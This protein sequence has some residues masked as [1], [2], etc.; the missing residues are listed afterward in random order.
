MIGATAQGFFIGLGLVSPV[1]MQNTWVLNQG[2]R[3]NHHL[4]VACLCGVCDVFLISVGVNAHAVFQSVGGEFA[5]IMTNA[6][7]IF[8]AAY[9]AMLVYGVIC[10]T[11]SQTSSSKSEPEKRTGQGVWIV[12][13]GTLLVTLLNPHVLAERIVILG[14][15]SSEV[16]VDARLSFTLGAIAASF[17]WFFCLSSAAAKLH[18]VLSRP[19]VRNVVDLSVAVLLTAVAAYLWMDG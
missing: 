12:V 6:A 11:L 5:E 4:L 17:V 8:L 10:R 19:R 16:A 15:I 14:A 1:G 9:S 13:L 3:R 7:T 2:M 18:G